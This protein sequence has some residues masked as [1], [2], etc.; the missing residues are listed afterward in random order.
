MT[1]RPVAADRALGGLP[2]RCFAKWTAGLILAAA[3]SSG[4]SARADETVEKLGNGPAYD[5]VGEVAVM[6]HGRVKP[7]D[8]V[9]REEVKQVYGRET[10][11][12]R[13]PKE[14]IA[15]VL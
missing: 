15:K 12:L 10:V 8:T 2:M 9:A 14:E 3:L 4:L 13:E 5:R 6:H 7:L 11:T 1:G